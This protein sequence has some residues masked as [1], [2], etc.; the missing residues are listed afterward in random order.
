MITLSNGPL[1][2]EVSRRGAAVNR[3]RLAGVDLLLGHP[4]EAS[5]AESAWYMGE[6]VGPLANRIAGGVLPLPSGTRRVATNDRGNTLHGGPAGFSRHDWTVVTQSADEV[7]LAL[8]WTDPDGGFPGRHH[9][10]VTYR[11]APDALSHRIEVVADADTVLGPCSHPY[12]NLAGGGDVLDH[13]LR[14]DAAAYL[15]IDGVGIPLAE[16]PAPVDGTAFDLRGGV[17]LRDVVTAADPQVR[18][19]GGIDH[20]FVLSGG[21]P[22]AVLTHPASG[23]QLEV[24]TDRPALQVFTGAGMA[25]AHHLGTGAVPYAGVALEAECLPDAP[26]RP[27][28][29]SAFVAAGTPWVSETT[30]RIGRA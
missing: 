8:D 11:L 28:F 21:R 9:A 25:D 4:S 2:A 3:W 20:A 5:R 19:V 14:V 12:F 23:L 6:I 16:A 18:G 17:R 1:T 26:N 22:A 24:I 27:D 7:T 15:P 13:V 10:T 30:W 29:P